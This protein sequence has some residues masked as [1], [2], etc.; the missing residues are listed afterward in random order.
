MLTGCL[1]SWFFDGY[2]FYAWDAFLWLGG[3]AAIESNMKAWR[4]EGLQEAVATR[5]LTYSIGGNRTLFRRTIR[6]GYAPVVEPASNTMV[7][8]T[9]TVSMPTDCAVGSSTV[10]RSSTISGPNS[11]RSA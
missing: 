7:P 11:T 4:A 8:L 10:A 6:P 2:L 9:Q 5:H 3:F 1:L